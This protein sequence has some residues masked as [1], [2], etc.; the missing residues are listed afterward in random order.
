MG[1]KTWRVAIVV[2]LVAAIA[3]ILILKP[4]PPDIPEQTAVEPSPQTATETQSI[5]SKEALP[6]LVDLGAGTCIP[7][8]KMA[9][10]LEELKEEYAGKLEVVFIDVRE[11]PWAGEQYGIRVIPTQ[12]FYDADGEELSRHEGFLGKEDILQ[13]FRDEGLL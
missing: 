1:T 7:C 12:I 6:R 10:I 5:T 3:A 11:S 4:S 8:K 2:L 13:R 9:P